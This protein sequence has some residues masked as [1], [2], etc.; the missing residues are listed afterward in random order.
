V[1]PPVH[2]V[3]A[4]MDGGFY[5]VASNLNAREIWYNQINLSAGELMI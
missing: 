3:D 2:A 5:M 4:S 1:Q